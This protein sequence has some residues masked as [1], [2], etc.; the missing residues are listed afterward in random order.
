MLLENLC[1]HYAALLSGER[2]IPLPFTVLQGF[3][4][5][6][7][8]VREHKKQHNDLHAVHS[9]AQVDAVCQEQERAG[10]KKSSPIS[11]K[12]LWVLSLEK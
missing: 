9:S 4:C 12:R 3:F 2:G 11:Q 8:Y 1:P 7:Q 6:A 10:L 5:P